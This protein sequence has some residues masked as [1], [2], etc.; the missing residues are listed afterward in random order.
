MITQTAQPIQGELNA[1]NNVFPSQKPVEYTFNRKDIEILAISS[2]VDNNVRIQASAD[3][4]DI[5]VGDYVTWQSGGY[6]LRSNKVVS[7]ISPDTIEVLLQFSSTDASSGWMNYYRRYYLEARFVERD[8]VTDEQNAIVIIGYNSQISNDKEGNITLD[9]ATV[10]D[11]ITPV[12][13]LSVDVQPTLTTG[14]KIQ[15]RESWDNNR[16]GAWVSPSLDVPILL[17]HASKDITFNEFIDESNYTGKFWRGYPL[18]VGLIHSSVNDNGQNTVKID[19]N[20]H[21]I[22]K[23]ISS[24]IEVSNDFDLN[25]LVIPKI[26]PADIEEGIVYLSFSATITGEA[27]QYDPTQ[28]DPTQYA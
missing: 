18:V 13:D 23:S 15:Y 26:Y 2:G 4:D 9:C 22:D 25:G 10:S 19:A 24:T 3:F 8:T 1:Y 21:L 5:Q 14:F 27:R 16:D 11:L 28:Y 7:I 12:I 6:S 20:K 17:V